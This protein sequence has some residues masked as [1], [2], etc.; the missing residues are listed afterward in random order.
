MNPVNFFL[1]LEQF[2]VNIAIFD[3]LRDRQMVKLFRSQPG[4]E[5]ESEDGE[6]IFFI[7]SIDNERQ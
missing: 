7:R 6:T 4:W 3:S 2:K 5:V 1:L